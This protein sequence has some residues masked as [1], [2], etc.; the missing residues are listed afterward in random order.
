MFVSKFYIAFSIPGSNAFITAS[1]DTQEYDQVGNVVTIGDKQFTIAASRRPD[2]NRV[3]DGTKLY[4]DKL[5]SV[6]M[7]PLRSPPVI[8]SRFKQL[9]Q[10][11]W[12][13]NKTKFIQKHWH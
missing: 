3:K 5:L 6:E 12:M 2:Y 7:K 4:W 9:E 10:T 11:G 8:I 13:L 1:I